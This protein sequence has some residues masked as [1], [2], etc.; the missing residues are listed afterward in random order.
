M[1]VAW[2]AMVEGNANAYFRGRIIKHC[3]NAV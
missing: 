2:L 1:Q 3:L